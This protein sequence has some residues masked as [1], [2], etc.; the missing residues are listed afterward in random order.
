LII[1]STFAC[2]IVNRNANSMRIMVIFQL[3]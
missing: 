3:Q 2:R 1:V